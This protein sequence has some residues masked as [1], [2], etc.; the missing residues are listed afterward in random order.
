M[1]DVLPHLET[2]AVILLAFHAH[3]SSLQSKGLPT[4]TGV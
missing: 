2:F 3:P 1:L 4:H